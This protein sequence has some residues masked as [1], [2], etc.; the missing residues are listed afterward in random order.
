MIATAQTE[1]KGRIGSK[2]CT[3]CRLLKPRSQFSLQINKRYSKRQCA[4]VGKVYLRS[5]CKQCTAVYTS[6]RTKWRNTLPGVF[7][8]GA[9]NVLASDRR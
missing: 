9:G 1:P 7:P 3:K 5:R 4:W 8:W 2:R 6:D